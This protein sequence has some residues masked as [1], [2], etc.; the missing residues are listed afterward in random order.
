[1]RIRPKW[2]KDIASMLFTAYYL[3]CAEAADEVVRK[4]R[5]KLSLE[6]LRVS[7]NK[8]TT[9]YL[10]F[11]GRVLRP[12]RLRMRYRPRRI[13]IPRPVD[14]P[15]KK[16]VH[17]WLYY[18]G[19]L[20][21]LK[22]QDKV[23]LDVPGGGF[24]A[25]D[26]RCH[27]DKLMT[28][29][30]KTGF[31]IVSLDY[32]KA[33][34]YPYP[35]ALNECFDAYFSIVASR[36]RLIGLPGDTVPK[37]LLSGD[38]AGGNLA[39]GTC[40]MILQARSETF[41]GMSNGRTA[42]RLPLPEALVLVYPALD[43]NMTSWL[44]DDQSALIKDPTRRKANKG[45]VRKKTEDYHTMVNTSYPSDSEDESLSIKKRDK[46][47]SSK[48]VGT[49]IDGPDLS[50]T[51]VEALESV[52]TTELAAPSTKHELSASRPRALQT[53][54]EMTSMISY[55]DD[56]VLT[57]E[58]LRA[59]IILYLGEHKR[60]DFSTEY[61]LSPL[62]APEELLR[63]FPK[64]YMLTGER[65]PL[66]DDTALFAGRLLEAHLHEFQRRK[67]AGI[68]SNSQEFRDADHVHYELVPGVSH[69]FL[70]FALV[71]ARGYHLIEKC[72]TWMKDVFIDADKRES[73]EDATSGQDEY[74]GRSHTAN[75]KYHRPRPVLDS[76]NDDRPLEMPS[77]SALSIPASSH[78]L[79]S[80]LSGPDRKDASGKGRIKKAAF[81]GRKSPVLTRNN[82]SLLNLT[83]MNDDTFM[84]RRMG[85]VTSGLSGD[86]DRPKTPL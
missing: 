21:D 72:S 74:F 43:V 50:C 37:I 65:D 82:R 2:L 45:V 17:A 15:Y 23:I 9:P 26:P 53:R 30:V 35:Y 48:K 79:S 32:R 24:V 40:L 8:G 66:S 51:E 28:W 25:M 22:N 5:G 3:V 71:Y 70:Q 84:Q 52:P 34:E 29:A 33:P 27:D 14:S 80:S 11:F 4:V 62:R 16:P 61:L 46:S 75:A 68:I 73:E 44:T 10:A 54:L 42:N 60:P 20:E 77:L 56:R 7:W 36:G 86:Q 41:D 12:A 59:M 55:V 49:P 31:P 18:D 67:E 64:V 39:V 57:P 85:G 78:K 19:P 83:P 47:F 6:H 38:S 63:D 13:R 76:D 1:M 69:G 81:S 58:M